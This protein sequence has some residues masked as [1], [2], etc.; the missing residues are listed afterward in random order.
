MARPRKTPSG[1]GT[2]VVSVRMGARTKEKLEGIAREWGAD[3][4]QVM[5]FILAETT[6]V[7]FKRL[8]FASVSRIR[9]DDRGDDGTPLTE[10]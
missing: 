7:D 3:L 5:R 9:E 10:E 2:V 1:H 4:T 8:V 6:E